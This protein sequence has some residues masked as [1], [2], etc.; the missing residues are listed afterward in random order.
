VATLPGWLQ[1][2]ALAL[3]PTYVFEGLRALVVNHTFEAGYM[4]KALLLNL[5]YFATGAAAFAFFL[6]RA[7][8]NGS[9][10]QMGE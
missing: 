10:V 7:R 9:L 5:A 6:Q 2:V 3:P 1:P 8:V 4:V